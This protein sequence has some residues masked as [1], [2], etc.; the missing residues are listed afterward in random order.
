MMSLPELDARFQA[1]IQQFWQVRQQQQQTSG[2]NDAGTRGAVT[3][4]AQMAALEQPVVALLVQ[5]S[6]NQL[7]ICAQKGK[8][9]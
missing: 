3:G 7:D 8:A 9:L 5:S 1:A 2:I 6:L 4:G